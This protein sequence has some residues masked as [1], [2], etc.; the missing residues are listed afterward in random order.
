MVYIQRQH[1]LNEAQ[2]MHEM[3]MQLYQSKAVYI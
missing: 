1:V 2:H 3:H